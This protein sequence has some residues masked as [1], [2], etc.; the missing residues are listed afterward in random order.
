MCVWGGGTPELANNLR[1]QCKMKM[2]DLLV[3]NE[4]FQD[5]ERRAWD[6]SKGKAPVTVQPAC[7]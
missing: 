2:Q 4:E 7:S 6:P 1:V 5:D 3:E